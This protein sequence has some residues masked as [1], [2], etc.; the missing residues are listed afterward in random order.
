M[1]VKDKIFIET[2]KM[3]KMRFPSDCPYKVWCSKEWNS[4]F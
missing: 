4:Y 3:E 1:D 2:R